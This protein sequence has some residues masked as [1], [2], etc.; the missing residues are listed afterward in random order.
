MRCDYRLAACVVLLGGIGLL[1]AG[2]TG[3][4][5]QDITTLVMEGDFIT[6][7]G[8]VTTIDNIA[9]NSTGQWL[10]EADTNFANA[11]ADSVL[12][13]NGELYWR[14]DDPVKAP[15]GAHLDSF[16]SITLN[17]AA[18][19]G[20][21]FFLSGT[22]GTY[23]DSGVYCDHFGPGSDPF[24]GTV[25]VV[26]ESEEAP[27]LT[28][29]TPFIGFFDVKINNLDHLSCVASVDDPNI[30]TS[31]DRALYIFISDPDNGG[32]VDYTLIA[33]EG[34]ILPGQTEGIADFETGPHGSAINDG[35]NVL[36]GADLDGDSATD[37]VV[38][39]YDHASGMNILLAQE[40]F[41]SPI[42]DRNWV[43]LSSTK[44]GLSNNGD[45][46][47]SGR[48]TGDTATDSIIIVNGEKFMQE[49]DAPPGIA[50][51]FVLTSFGTGPLRI[52]DNGDV[53]WYG[54]WDDP[55]T[56]IDTGLFL[57]DRLLVQEGV[58]EIEGV[59]VDTIRGVEDGYHLSSNGRFVIFEAILVD[60]REGAFLIDMGT[61][62][63][64]DVNLDGVVDIDDLFAILGHWGEGPGQYDVN[65][66]GNVDIDDIFAILGAWGPCP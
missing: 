18:H 48:L 40:G 49:G 6:P 61:D 33:K 28:P 64:E 36:Y 8:N 1:A 10:V 43:A 31:V 58:T 17:D 35:D 59:V 45:Y 20:F 27:G 21:N 15:D 23:D 3:Q 32:I 4:R 39:L 62:C 11:D 29:G 5:Q 41:P 37:G 46:V 63:P 55:N 53:L 57:N 16:D 65:N 60:G 34:D 22:G 56:D 52:S 9:V 38:Y 25:A 7:V 51:D 19:S 12:L 47:F 54:D 30:P 13:R 14:E 24:D 2:P 44:L 42:P 50:G 66:D 26:Q